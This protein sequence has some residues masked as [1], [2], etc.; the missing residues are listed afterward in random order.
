[1]S[2]CCRLSACV[3]LEGFFVSREREREV[4]K[5]G[6]W[7]EERARERAETACCLWVFE[8]C[9]VVVGMFGRRL[10]AHTYTHTVGCCLLTC[11][12][13]PFLEVPWLLRDRWMTSFLVADG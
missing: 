7:R 10:L 2:P 11:K 1:M 9:G 8:M 6:L 3:G 4:R 12:M 13:H 5:I